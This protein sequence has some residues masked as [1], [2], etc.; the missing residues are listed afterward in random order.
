LN[1]IEVVPTFFAL[2]LT[3]R[4]VLFVEVFTPETLPDRVAPRTRVPGESSESA[5][6]RRVESVPLLFRKLPSVTLG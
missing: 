5:A 2:N 1:W 6:S 3:E 4:I